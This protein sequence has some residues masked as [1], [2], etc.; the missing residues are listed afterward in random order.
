MSIDREERFATPHPVR[1]EVR[2]PSGTIN[3][4][5]TN[6]P[7]SS[8]KLE[9]SP[10]LIEATNVEIIREEDHGRPDRLIVALRKKAFSHF[11]GS[12]QVEIAIPHHSSVEI[13]TA[14]ADARLEGTFASLK[15]KSASGDLTVLGEVEG[16]ASTQTVSG[17]LRLSQI[18]GDLEAQTVS[19]EVEAE[20]VAGSATVRSV[21]GDLCIG[22]VREGR[23]NVQSVSG[24]VSLGIAPGTNVDVDAASTSGELTSEVSLAD[25][26][27]AE[28]GPTVVV[29]GNTVSGDFRLFRAA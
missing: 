22:S 5:S 3:V 6:P 10:K 16:D 29:R 2:V 24:D 8:V 26:P 25:A 19:G 14:A 28:A 4:V 20:L 11:D 12:L 21:S 1:L 15:T 9:G 13:T 7:E 18:G 27:T 17:D 23:V